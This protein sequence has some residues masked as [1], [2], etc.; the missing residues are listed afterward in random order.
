MTKDELISKIKEAADAYYSGRELMSD[1]EYDALIE[2]LR[3]VDPDNPIIAGLAGDEDEQEANAAGYP[4]IKHR[5]TTGT[6]SK[7]MTLEVFEKW[8]KS[9]KGPYHV[10]DKMDGAGS[11][12]VYENGKLVHLISRGNGYYGYDKLALAKYLPIPTELPGLKDTVSIR[13]EFELSNAVFKSHNCF[14]N[15]K[16]PRNAGSGLLNKKVDDLT[17]EEIDAMKEL[18][19][20]AYDI[21]LEKEF[22]SKDH[23]SVIFQL[24]KG[25]GFET[26]VNRVCQTYDEVIQFREERSKIRGTD[27]EE[28]ATDG[29]VVFEERLDAK[30]QLEK[31]QKKAIAIKYDLMVAEGTIL[32]I[33]WSMAGAYLTPVAIMTPMELDG[34]TVQRANL[35]NLNIISKLGIKIGDK[36]KVWKRGEIIPQIFA[37]TD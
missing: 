3:T 21:L 9:H 18:K 20:F 33:E 4:K 14:K 34:T 31:I 10:S 8:V 7:A 36:V 25:M 16:N 2:E 23:K 17:A 32:D 22:S 12:L 27:A 5:L 26:P 6:L 29:I 24:L 1:K 35:C 28:F 37:K 11:E 30:D 19:F 15:M 13:G